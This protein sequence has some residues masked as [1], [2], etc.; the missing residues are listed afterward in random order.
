MKSRTSRFSVARMLAVPAVGL[1]M[2][3][4]LSACQASDTAAKSGAASTS[5]TAAAVDAS[6]ST[7]GQSNTA[8]TGAGEWQ[9]LTY[10]DAATGV[11][12]SYNLFL[13]AGYDPSESYPLVLFM[14]DAS[15]VGTTV[16]TPI[17]TGVGATV[18]ASDRVQADNPAIVVAP[19]YTSVTIGDDYNPTS[20]LDTTVDL[21]KSLAGEYSVDT[22]RIYNTG[23]SM[24]AMMTIG[25]D[26]EY[27]D[28]FAASYIVAGQWP[29]EATEA[30]ADQNIWYTVAEGDTKAYPG[31][32]AIR[33]VVSDAG[34][35]VAGGAIDATASESDYATF[36]DGI[37][38]QNANFNYTVFNAG[39]DLA[40]GAQME[41]MGT[42]DYAYDITGIQDWLFAQS[43]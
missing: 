25:M 34:A 32:V 20:D 21:V 36:V 19:Q 43:K 30:L 13:P 41:H 15:M 26:I 14:E 3:I 5:V 16:T 6:D 37:V 11:E 29:A 40:D 8:V 24:G 22:N 31:M 2:I 9:Q 42:W 1:S 10:T 28:L 23:Q 35:T 4:S 27:P 39:T 18:W 17:D 38:A 12:L 7:A 33:D